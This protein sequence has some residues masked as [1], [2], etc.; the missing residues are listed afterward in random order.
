M[1]CP[2]QTPVWPDRPEGA[3]SRATE[4]HWSPIG[5]YIPPV[6]NPGP[7]EAPAA[8]PHTIILDPVQTAVCPARP[9]GEPLAVIRRQESVTG[10][11][12]PPEFSS[13]PTICPPQTIIVE[14]VHTAVWPQRPAGAPMEEVGVQ[15]SVTGS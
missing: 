1:R 10:S 13:V 8:P 7:G 12:W 14:P 9:W 15:V 5:S 6:L 11:Y 2:V 4:L 3:S